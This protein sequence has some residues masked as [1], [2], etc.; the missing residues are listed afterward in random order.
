M[1]LTQK[2]FFGKSNFKYKGSSNLV[3]QTI[4]R[5]LSKTQMF[6]F[7]TGLDYLHC[8]KLHIISSCGRQFSSPFV[9]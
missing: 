9:N 4:T 2:Q 7:I 5:I 1:K 8:H 6:S 3:L